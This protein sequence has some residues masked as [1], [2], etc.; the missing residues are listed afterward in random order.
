M[1][2]DAVNVRKN[3]YESSTDCQ[4]IGIAKKAMYNLAGSAFYTMF[5]TPNSLFFHTT[6]LFMF[7]QEESIKMFFKDPAFFM[8]SPAATDGAVP[9]AKANADDPSWC[10]LTCGVKQLRSIPSRPLEDR[11]SG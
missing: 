4:Q 9:A 6:K 1:T 10:C 8:V 11:P 3:D 7:M 5:F 2:A